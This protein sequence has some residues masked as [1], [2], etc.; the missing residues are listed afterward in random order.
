MKKIILLSILAISFGFTACEKNQSGTTTVNLRMTDAP[1]DFEAIILNIKEVEVK[2]SA[3]T[4]L[5]DV[6]GGAFD[7]LKFRNGRDTLIASENI[8]TGTLKEV[9]LILEPTGNMVIIDGV[10]Y[11][12]K[13]PSG[14]SSG[15]KIKVQ[16][17]LVDGVAY[18]LLLDFD[19]AKSI[20]NTGNG[21]YILKPV[22]RA[23]PNAVSGA[24]AGTVTPLAS[25]PLIYAINGVDTVGTIIDATGKFYF[26]GIAAGTYK[27]DF[28]TSTPYVSKSL[29]NITVTTGSVTNV[30]A[31][32]LSN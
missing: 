27:I 31:V 10:S 23:V 25:A 14:Q 30:G 32:N 6:K 2:T 7:I 28:V 1:G 8:A 29:N 19:A 18:T 24:I 3:G 11:D 15:V 16:E 22:I 5:L 26:N 4:A 9:R 20:V 21:K 17:E 13:T 12:L